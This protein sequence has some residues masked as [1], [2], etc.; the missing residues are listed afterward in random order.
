MSKEIK[1]LQ[2]RWNTILET[3]HSNSHV[4]AFM[5]SQLGRYLDDRP[6]VS[7]SLLV[8]IA[9][10][11]IPVVF[12]LVFVVATT[13]IACVGVIIME[14]FLISL[15]GVT[16][17]CVLIGLGMVSLAVSGVLSV[18]Y[19]S[20]TTLLNYWPTPQPSKKEF[21]NECNVLRNNPPDLD[22]DAAKKESE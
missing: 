22:S 21:A 14:G 3:V 8:F 18:F 7:L 12:F 15:G 1:S 5:N 16:L 10:A 11:A 20:L 6:F 17:L 2:K 4:V 9:A 13:V 19:L